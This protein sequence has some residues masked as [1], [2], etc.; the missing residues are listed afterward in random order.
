ME[1]VL[2]NES[3]IS[4]NIAEWEVNNT[5]I[6]FQVK[7][8]CNGSSFKTRDHFY[9]KEFKKKIVQRKKIKIFGEFLRRKFFVFSIHSLFSNFSVLIFRFFKIRYFQ[10]KPF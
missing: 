8:I 4:D 6:S 3:F 5:K 9:F 10:T 2:R 1:E 7:N